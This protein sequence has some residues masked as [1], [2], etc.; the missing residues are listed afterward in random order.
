MKESLDKDFARFLEQQPAVIRALTNDF[1]FPLELQLKFLLYVFELNYFSLNAIVNEKSFQPTH[2]AERNLGKP[3]LSSEALAGLMQ[4]AHAAKKAE[5]T[6]TEMPLAHERY[7][8]EAAAAIPLMIKG[9]KKI[10]LL[11]KQVEMSKAEKEQ[12]Y[13]FNGYELQRILALIKS[14]VRADEQQSEMLGIKQKIIEQQK[15]IVQ[16]MKKINIG[17]LFAIFSGVFG[18]L[19]G[20]QALKDLFGGFKLIEVLQGLGTLAFLFFAAV[21]AFR[22]SRSDDEH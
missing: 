3:L 4:S 14:L 8:V 19:Q 12:N 11:C 16:A 10:L 2:E 17:K 6:Q 15:Q 1:A 13:V 5:S 20:W 9:E 18:A 7:F 22:L 21:V